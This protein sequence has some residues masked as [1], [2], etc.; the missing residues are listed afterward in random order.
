LQKG[1][2]RWQV[3]AFNKDDKK[4]SESPDDIKFTVN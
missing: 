4:L 2:Y 1:S 3:D